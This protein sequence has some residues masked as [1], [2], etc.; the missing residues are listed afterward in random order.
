MFFIS[1]KTKMRTCTQCQNTLEDDQFMRGDAYTSTCRPC[2]GRGMRCRMKYKDDRDQMTKT[3]KKNNADYI[4]LYNEFYR[5]STNL[6]HEERRLLLEKVKQENQIPDKRL[7]TPSP[8]RK[9]HTDVNGI[10]GKFCSVATCGW[11]PLTEFNFKKNAW[12]NL[13][14]VKNVWRIN[15]KNIAGR[16]KP[17]IVTNSTSSS[18]SD[19]ISPAGLFSP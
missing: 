14:L 19:K 4:R 9:L 5:T 10:M 6:P 12:D 7:G 1:F 3:W 2:R 15:E 13:R 11:Q 8:H 16:D 17:I 18:G